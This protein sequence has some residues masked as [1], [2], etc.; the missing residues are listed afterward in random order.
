MAKNIFKALPAAVAQLIDQSARDPKIDSLNPD[1]GNGREEIA[2]VSLKHSQLCWSSCKNILL[3][4]I[5][6]R[7]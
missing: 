3:L 1:S 6:L 7:V 5:R 4:M 2:K